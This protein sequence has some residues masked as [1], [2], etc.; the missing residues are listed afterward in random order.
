M[1][2]PRPEPWD[3]SID[4]HETPR[5][6]RAFLDYC[7]MQEARSLRDLVRRYQAQMEQ[8]REDPARNQYGPSTEKPPTIYLSTLGDWSRR[9]QWQIRVQYWDDEQERLRAERNNKE[10]ADMNRRQAQLGMMGQQKGIAKLQS[11][12]GTELTVGE[13][14]RLLDVAT[15]I[16]RVARGEPATIESRAR[17]AEWWPHSHKGDRGHPAGQE[18]AVSQGAG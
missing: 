1:A 8:Y 5:A 18:T 17:W 10:I 6:Y 3:R 15:K 2:L 13:A 11:L 4:T 14:I 12:I 7:W 9:H 16:E